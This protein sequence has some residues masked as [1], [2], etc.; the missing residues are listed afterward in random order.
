M[1]RNH[2]GLVRAYGSGV[3]AQLEKSLKPK[4]KIST[5]H[6]HTPQQAANKEEHNSPRQKGKSTKKAW[7][8]ADRIRAIFPCLVPGEPIVKPAI[9]GGPS[10][11][12]KSRRCRAA[13]L[14]RTAYF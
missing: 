6:N 8:A 4:T 9:F 3:V 2:G 1:P 7:K 5:L 14:L 13:G 12:T 11:G 10:E